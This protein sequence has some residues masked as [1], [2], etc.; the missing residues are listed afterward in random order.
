MYDFC[1]TEKV[2]IQISIGLGLLNEIHSWIFLQ[3][4]T[5]FF[6]QIFTNKYGLVFMKF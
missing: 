1:I 4:E 3:K 5:K 6:P 2:F